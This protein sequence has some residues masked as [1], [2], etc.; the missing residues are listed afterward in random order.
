MGKE[1]DAIMD[2][3]EDNRRFAD[4]F[5]GSLFQG[6]EI[7][8]AGDLIEGSEVYKE[9]GQ[10]LTG[11]KKTTTRIRD[12][13]K[14][15]KSGGSLKV[16][17]VENENQ[18]DYTMP[19]RVMNYDALEY[20]KQIQKI[21][22]E[23]K[24]AKILK[25]DAEFISGMRTEDRLAPV[26]TLCVYHGEKK[27]TGPRSLKDMMDFG[28]DKELWEQFFSDYQMQIMCIN[29]MTDFD[30]FASPLKELLMALACRDDKEKLLKLMEENERYQKI[31]VETAEVI[32][33]MLG[34]EKMIQV[35]VEGGEVNM[36]KALKGLLEDSKTEGMMLGIE[37]GIEQGI[38]LII[39]SMKNKGLGSGEIAKLTGV[40]LERVEKY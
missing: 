39:K 37:Q 17:A 19:W 21:S 23:N 20:G 29:E 1:S 30:R 3:L 24:D 5:N 7:V 36:C 32:G 6:K 16:L 40:E 11:E 13:K 26:F 12:I 4:L 35:N 25:T 38:G 8:S 27:W 28:E 18:V 9:S 14:R 10:K 34:M 22:R 15:L 33:V 2:Y 31:D